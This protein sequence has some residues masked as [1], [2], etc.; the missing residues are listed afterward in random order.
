MDQREPDLLWQKQNP[1]WTDRLRS[2]S[3]SVNNTPSKYDST[4]YNFS[5]LELI[6]KFPEKRS[7][8]YDAY[9]AKE[10]YGHRLDALKHCV[11]NKI[12]FLMWNCQIFD[13]HCNLVD[14]DYY[15][16]NNS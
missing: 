16:L 11:D 6:K 14:V 15:I 8:V 4:E 1:G 7:D 10:N 9:G 13:W 3:E 2:K 5:K 12:P